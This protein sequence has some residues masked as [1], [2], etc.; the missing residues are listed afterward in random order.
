VV[1]V[2]NLVAGGWGV[3]MALRRKPAGKGL[4]PLIY[5]GQA[6]LALQVVIGVTLSRRITPPGIHMF[7]GFVLL[8]AAALSYAFRGDSPRRMLTV[9]A[10]VALFVG[11]VGVRTMLTA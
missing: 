10:A 11:A 5:A 7:Y 9:C 1:V 4:W 8:I 6:A 3:W 2:L